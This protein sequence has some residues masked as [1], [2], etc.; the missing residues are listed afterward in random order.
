MSG[1]EVTGIVLG[2][3]PL[4]QESAK[5]LRV[6]LGG[7]KTWWRFEREFESFVATI[8]MEYIKFSQ[9]LEILLAEV[10]V[11]DDDRDRLQNDSTC[12][13]CPHA[14]GITVSE[15]QTKRQ[16][17]VYMKVLFREEGAQT[18]IKIETGNH[19]TVHDPKASQ[20]EDVTQLRQHVAMKN[21]VEDTRKSSPKSI[22]MLAAG[23]L[24]RN[25][26][27]PQWPSRRSRLSHSIR[28][29]VSAMIGGK[30]QE[31]ILTEPSQEAALQT[32]APTKA[33]RFAAADPESDT[34]FTTAP[35][36]N[37]SIIRDLCSYLSGGPCRTSVGYLQATTST[38]LYLNLDPT[39]QTRIQQ[40]KIETIEAFLKATPSRVTR[41]KVG[42]DLALVILM[43][44]G[45][46]WVPQTWNKTDL[47]LV[48]DAGNPAPQPFLN[49][50]SLRQTLAVAQE[51][52]AA[53]KARSI[54][55]SLGVLLLELVFR[56]ELEN[57]P[58][59]AK[60]MGSD[61]A[62]NEE[63]DFATALLWQQR[64]E[65]EFGDE[66]A[67]A[68]KRCLICIFDMAPSPDLNNSV[69]I[70]AIWQQVLLPVDKF[71]SAWSRV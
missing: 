39:D 20:L 38:R 43:L 35:E 66:L 26:D 68:I 28:R 49:L 18:Q 37:F 9:N 47:F 60:L 58:F 71:L 1:F 65:E 5:G 11:S 51:G 46:G 41:I 44:G 15:L 27:A 62:P 61:G 54:L 22:F 64:V 69:F 52:S 42:F 13:L 70:Q 32:K 7:A 3:F 10:D 12:T 30:K 8:E 36:A 56:E 19:I 45:S 16:K 55:F 31:P 63:T 40:H 25:P 24:S 17:S 67:D 50:H 34:L 21:R 29:S 33:V 48:R 4:I 23:P 59:R 57:Q 53:K 2:V 6:V 14:F